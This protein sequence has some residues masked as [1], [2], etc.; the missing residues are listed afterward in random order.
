MEND[1]LSD[2]E[3]L[4]DDLEFGSEGEDIPRIRSRFRKLKAKVY[5]DG[6]AGQVIFEEGHVFE[7]ITYFREKLKEYA[8]QGWFE[9]AYLKNE[10]SRVTAV[11]AAEG[12]E[13]RIHATPN[14]KQK[15]TFMVRTLRDVHQC[16]RLTKNS[17]ANSSWLAKKILP[18]LRLNP[19]MDITTI[20]VEFQ[21][22]YGIKVPYM[23][24]YRALRKAKECV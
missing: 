10:K 12:C 14:P 9:L 24:A 2:Y 7:N 8:V 5:R 21:D 17:A 1:R 11:C 16:M 3:S 18:K 6:P 20:K 13:W 22:K 15:Q 4:S 19:K 23:Q